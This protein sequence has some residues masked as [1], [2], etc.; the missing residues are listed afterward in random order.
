MTTT[1]GEVQLEVCAFNNRD[2]ARDVEEVCRNVNAHGLSLPD[3]RRLVMAVVERLRA[4]PLSA[5]LAHM[6]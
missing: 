5:P 1:E 4:H 2:L 3:G 6:G